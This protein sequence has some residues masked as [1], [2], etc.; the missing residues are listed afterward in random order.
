M[1]TCSAIYRKRALL[2][3]L[4]YNYW[5]IWASIIHIQWTMCHYGS[6]G[7]MC[8]NMVLFRLENADMT[9]FN[10]ALTLYILLLLWKRLET[11]YTH[12][13]QNISLSKMQWNQ[14]FGIK[15]RFHTPGRLANFV[16]LVFCKLQKWPQ[17][18]A[19]TVLWS[20]VWWL[21]KPESFTV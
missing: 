13:L 9:L 1:R 17:I 5:F 16:E 12:A 8:I 7:M 2:T 11:C 4:K 20:I 18:F 10:L 19:A 15:Y 14:F 21:S 6:Q 3:H